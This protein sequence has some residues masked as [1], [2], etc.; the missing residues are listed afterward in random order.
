MS[1]GGAEPT[2]REGAGVREL[3]LVRIKADSKTR[4]EIMQICDIF[5]AKIVNVAHD[6][7][8]VEITGDEAKI[9]AFLKLIEAFGI[10]ELARTGQLAFMR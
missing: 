1:Q 4:S 6:A 10:L 3:V 7:L 8:I 2:H 5:R 9:S